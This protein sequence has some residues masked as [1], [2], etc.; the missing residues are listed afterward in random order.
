MTIIIIILIIIIIIIIISS[1]SSSSIGKSC[2]FEHSLDI[3][4]TSGFF[5]KVSKLHEPEGQMQF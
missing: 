1:S 3:I 2:N 4:C 5:Q